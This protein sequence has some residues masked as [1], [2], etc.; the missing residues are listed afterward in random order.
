VV[1]EDDCD[2]ELRYA[3]HPIAALQG[4]DEDGRVF[5]VGT[6][7][8]V[9]YPGLRTGYVVPPPSVRREL[10][11]TI[12]AGDR[13]P[14]AV[15]QR[16][17]ALFLEQGHFERHLRRLRLAFAERQEALLDALHRQLPGFFRVASAPA[18]THLVAT[19]ADERWSA[20]TLARAFA[21]YEVV[22]EPMSFSRIAPAPD[23][24]VLLHYA[25]YSP[26]QLALGVRQMAVAVSSVGARRSA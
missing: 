20:T 24:Q 8:K 23:D 18:G 10:L 14:G 6:F 3:G 9:L 15:E 25:R 5:Y 2:S 13:G 16:A 7:S 19:V 26:A 1:I 11:A 22:I 12:E 21:D 4:L 17:L